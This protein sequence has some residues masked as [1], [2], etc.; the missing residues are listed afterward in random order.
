MVLRYPE[1][2]AIRHLEVDARVEI[3]FGAE[4]TTLSRSAGGPNASSTFPLACLGD[5]YDANDRLETLSRS[6]LKESTSFGA[7]ALAVCA[8]RI[9]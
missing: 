1:A 4:L 2:K 6:L 5:R 8:S 9:A 3:A 7:G